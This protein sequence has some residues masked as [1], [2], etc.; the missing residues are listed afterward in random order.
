MRAMRRSGGPAFLLCLFILVFAGALLFATEDEE[1]IDFTA[2]RAD[3]VLRAVLAENSPYTVLD[4][5]GP[6]DA[7]SLMH[8]AW[9]DNQVEHFVR[10]VYR[11]MEAL[12][13][14]VGRAQAARLEA[15]SGGPDAEAAT[16]SWKEA[17]KETEE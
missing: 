10:D 1:K 8:E 16:V 15:V 13:A 17:L 4:E 5:S 14:A 11:K 12:R 3:P 2:A 7:E 9:V 6:P